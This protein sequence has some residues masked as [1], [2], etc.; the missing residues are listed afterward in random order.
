METSV[1]E[2]DGSFSYLAATADVFGFA[3]DPFC[4]KQLLVGEDVDAIAVANGESAL[5]AALSSPYTAREAGAGAV[6]VW[7]IGASSEWPGPP[8]PC[9][10]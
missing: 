3:K 8:R 9:P 6:A 4:L 1:K 7:K 2:L 5:H 10:Q